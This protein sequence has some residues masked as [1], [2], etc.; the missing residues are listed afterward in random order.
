[1]APLPTSTSGS[2]SRPSTPTTVAGSPPWSTRNTTAPSDAVGSCL[3]RTDDPFEPSSWRAWDGR[4]F[5][6]RFADPYRATP[7]AARPCAP[8]AT[9]EIAAMHESL[10][11][12]TYL[13]RYLLV[14]LT[15]LRGPSGELVTG[16]Y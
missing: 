10:T 7:G 4:G 3:I 11:Y 8:I 6:I 13:D 5:G 1:M 9:P 15:S 12:N 14:G 16:V 2:G